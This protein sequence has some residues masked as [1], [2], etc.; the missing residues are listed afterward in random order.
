MLGEKQTR[1]AG[2]V[3]KINQTAPPD[4]Q[5]IRGECHARELGAARHLLL[6]NSRSVLPGSRPIVAMSSM[7]IVVGGRPGTGKTSL[8]DGLARALDAVHLRIDTIERALRDSIA[9]GE[10]FGAAGY[11]VAHAVAADNLRLG[12]IVVVDCVN[13]PASTRAGWRAVALRSGVAI[14][15]VEMI[16]SDPFEHRRRVES[17]RSNTPGPELP[18]W[19]FISERQ[20]EPWAEDHVVIDT[21]H[22]PVEAGI[23]KV[24]ALLLARQRSVR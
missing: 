5:V 14:F 8:A 16:C 20:N 4:R 23:I 18:G 3:G 7:L 19:D 6:H 9:S 10:T 21:A 12:R 13:P 17:R 24:H 11:V 15:E 22:R 2:I 1:V